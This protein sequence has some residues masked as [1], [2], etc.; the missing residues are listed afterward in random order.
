MA[1]TFTK[2]G[3]RTEQRIELAGA[4]LDKLDICRRLIE[5]HP[6]DSRLA[7]ARQ[8]LGCAADQVAEL[9]GAD[10]DRERAAI[11]RAAAPLPVKRERPRLTLRKA[12]A[13]GLVAAGFL[14]VAGAA[15]VRWLP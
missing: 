7:L 4:I 2:A 3:A 11:R 6:V 9:A 15:V 1:E 10:D 8:L 14:F 12:L 13:I 5:M